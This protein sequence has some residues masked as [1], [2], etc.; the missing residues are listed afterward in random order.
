[1]SSINKGHV[2]KGKIPFA[3]G[4]VTQYNRYYI[5]LEIEDDSLFLINCSSVQG[6][7]NKLLLPSNVELNNCIPPLMVPTMVKMDE[8]Y[9]IPA[10][11]ENLF[12][13][14]KPQLNKD[15][16]DE[17]LNNLNSYVESKYTSQ[18]TI[19]SYSYEEISK[20]N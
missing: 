7:E 8:L 10:I 11:C 9:K 12:E 16:F 20:C 6:K 15:S 14:K 13:I 17:L 18:P 4:S 5:V 19:I 3:N 2:V 1:M